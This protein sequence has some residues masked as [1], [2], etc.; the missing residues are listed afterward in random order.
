[1]FLHMCLKKVLYAW[2]FLF[3]IR[4]MG[5]RERYTIQCTLNFNLTIERVVVCLWLWLWLTIQLLSLSTIIWFIRIAYYFSAPQRYKSKRVS[6]LLGQIQGLN[7]ANNN[8]LDEFSRFLLK[9]DGALILEILEDNV[10]L[11]AAA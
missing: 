1:M 5:E 10:S 4:R 9:P 3:Q 8:Q 7:T 6:L 11:V 2:L